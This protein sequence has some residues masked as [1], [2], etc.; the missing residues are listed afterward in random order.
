M[1]TTLKMSGTKK[2][3]LKKGWDL[4]KTVTTMEDPEPANR[5]LG[6]KHIRRSVS[7]GRNFDPR[8]A[9][10]EGLV[11]KKDK[12]GMKF[13]DENAN[14]T[15]ADAE[16]GASKTQCKLMDIGAVEDNKV[17]CIKYD[18]RKFLESC[19][20]RYLEICNKVG[21]KVNLAHAETPFM[22][23]HKPENDENEISEENRAKS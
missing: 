11:Y 21:A 19:V 1:W 23:E 15:P 4:I 13:G 16:R 8:H 6:C 3:N 2:N 9:P 22:D 18:N 17:N 7:I 12:P 20:S 14:L 10:V 5:F